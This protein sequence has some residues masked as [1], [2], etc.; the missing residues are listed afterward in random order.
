MIGRIARAVTVISARQA[1]QQQFNNS[2]INFVRLFS[3]TSRLDVANQKQDNE[4]LLF[5]LGGVD[6]QKP[7]KTVRKSARQLKTSD[8]EVTKSSPTRKA[9]TPKIN[10][11]I[12]PIESTKKIDRKSRSFD[13]LKY[14]DSSLNLTY[15]RL[16]RDHPQL[17]KL[18]LMLK[19]RK[20]RENNDLLTIE[21]RR[22]V[23]EVAEA[24]LKLK[25]LLFSNIHQLELVRDKLDPVITDETTIISVKHGDLTFW[26]T[27]NTCPGLIAIF[28]KPKDMTSIWNNARRL[29]KSSAAAS[30][31]L[32]QEKE[33][34][35]SEEEILPNVHSEQITVVCDQIREP[36]NI[37]GIIRTCAAIP[38]AKIIMLKGCA[39]PWDV[40]ALRGGCG[41]Q[42]R[43]PIVGPI[44]WED[45]QTHL[46]AVEDLSVY[47]ADNKTEDAVGDAIDTNSNMVPTDDD[48]EKT[49][50]RN[51]AK[52]FESKPYTEIP[53]GYCKHVVLIIGGETEG[54]SSHAYD[55]M[56]FVSAQKHNSDDSG[57]KVDKISPENS[58]VQI[59][60]GNGI[61]SL[62][63]GVATAI[64]LFEI[65]K[66]ICGA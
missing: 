6:V 46:P 45:L 28:E 33:S 17:P 47:I 58:V 15:V 62:N 63:A 60:L 44:D 37:G 29:V 57:E 65:R 11:K 1:R 34:D 9:K 5:D 18:M 21:G 40:K 13:E 2:H 26:S 20:Y 4:D 7:A 41:A 24:G 53:F 12:E 48:F 42:F 54:V 61:E 64:L 51:N 49:R 25:Y 38:C 35:T 43:V 55:F 39:D 3:Q 8:D 19:S 27:L 30:A 52:H 66:Q 56:K 10:K 36:N 32:N 14:Y 31:E 50:K 16:P 22:L 59:P 23:A